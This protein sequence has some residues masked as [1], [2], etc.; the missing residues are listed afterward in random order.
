MELKRDEIEFLGVCVN[1]EIESYK[2]QRY[3][4][5]EN[6]PN[7]TETIKDCSDY[8]RRLQLLEDK[9][10]KELRVLHQIR[11]NQNENRIM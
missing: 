6:E 11:R 10:E 5:K 2:E 3:W 8:I 1:K 9:L 4:Y 7:K